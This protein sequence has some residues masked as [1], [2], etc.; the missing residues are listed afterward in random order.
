MNKK[1]MIITPGFPENEQDSTCVPYLQDYVIALANKIGSEN[2]VVITMHYP[3]TQLPYH[4]NNIHVFPSGGKNKKSLAYYFTL[5]RTNQRINKLFK[6]DTYII[7]AFWMG[8]AAFVGRRAAARYHTNFVVTFMGQDVKPGNRVMRYI[9]NSKTT[10]VTLCNNHDKALNANYGFFAD[11]IVPFPIP[12]INL[13]PGKTRNIDLLFVGSLIEVKQPE[14]F[15]HIVKQLKERFVNI[16]TVMIGDGV[17][18][19]NITQLI[20]SLQLTDNIELK[21]TIPRNEVFNIMQQSKVL[22]HTSKWEGQCLAY[23][24]ALANGMYVVSY[25]VGR[26]EQTR[27]H[28]IGNTEQELFQQCEQLLSS[29][30]DFEPVKLLQTEV[31]VEQYLKWYTKENGKQKST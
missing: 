30:N 29:E 26:I 3:F 23:S 17:L 22:L 18:K 31:I 8:E 15:V 5:S 19:D 14:Q 16:K 13:Q 25:N 9:D 28:I 12:E 20:T 1:V 7:H 6:T 4:W 27:K 10:F 11:D 2:I 21:G 24:E